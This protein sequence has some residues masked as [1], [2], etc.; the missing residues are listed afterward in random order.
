MTM[1]R[2]QNNNNNWKTE[3]QAVTLGIVNCRCRGDSCGTTRIK[4]CCNL[5]GKCLE[6]G[7]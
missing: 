3:H 5:I 7:N 6:I 2:K 1:T 4:S